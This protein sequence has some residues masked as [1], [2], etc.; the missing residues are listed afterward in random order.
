MN[1]TNIQNLNPISDLSFMVLYKSQ[2]Q[3]I[4]IL[5]YI[6][7]IGPPFV[8]LYLYIACYACSCE[9]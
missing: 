5:Q 6:S 3:D 9:F 7:C 2:E 4:H 8:E 1:C